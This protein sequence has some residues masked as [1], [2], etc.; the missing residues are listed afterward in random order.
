MAD[1]DSKDTR[2]KPFILAS[3]QKGKSVAEAVAAISPALTDAGFSIIGTY[4]PKDTVVVLCLT[5]DG[6]KD[7]V[8]KSD[9]GGFAAAIRVGFTAIDDE[10][11]ISYTN[12][13]YLA[14]ACRLTGDF[15]DVADK[16]SAVLG[17]EKEFGSAKGLIEKKVRKYHYKIG[18]EYF[19]EPE[20]LHKYKT[21]EEAVAACEAALAEKKG[22]VT[23]VY[24]VDVPGKEE[25]V[26]GCGLAST[27]KFGDD[28]H[29]MSIIDSTPLKHSCHMPYEMLVSE[30]KVIMLHAR[31]RIAMNFPDLDMAGDNSFMKIMDTPKAIK[32]ALTAAAGGKS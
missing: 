8:S 28:N 15:A 24:R 7:L 1:E 29:I 10:V 30:A 2:Y 3:S 5:T 18:M 27:D 19:N 9:K 16:L 4:S 26:F 31:F 21:H 14:Y 6:I 20:T 11:Q 22:G 25:V 12:A 32:K 23:K 13:R 17:S